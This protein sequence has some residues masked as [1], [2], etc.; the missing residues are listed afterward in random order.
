MNKIA[1]RTNSKSYLERAKFCLEQGKIEFLFYA[2]LELRCC[3]EERQSEY[4][5][6]QEKYRESLPPSWKLGQQAAQL[7]KIYKEERA[8]VITYFFLDGF[9][10]V[11]RYIPVSIKLKKNAEK[12]GELLHTQANHI[13]DEQSKKIREHLQSIASDAECCLS[14]NALSPSL[15]EKSVKSDNTPVFS[16]NAIL[17]SEDTVELTK[18]AKPGLTILVEVQYVTLESLMRL[19]KA[20]P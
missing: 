16:T 19:E 20:K 4:L 18:R 1:Y 7:R 6:A 12:L 17:D 2:A 15:V 11:A 3:I 8:Q 9:Q 14:G 13:R 5:I 10:F